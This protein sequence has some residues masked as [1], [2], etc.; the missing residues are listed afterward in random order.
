MEPRIVSPIFELR[1]STRVEMRSRNS[2]NLKFTELQ[3]P[4]SPKT[5]MPKFSILSPNLENL[6]FQIHFWD[7]T[8]KMFCNTLKSLIEEQTRINEQG[9]IFRILHKKLRAG[10]T[11]NLKNLN[12]HAL[13]LG[14][15]EYYICRSE[16]FEL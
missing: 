15:S 3:N 11:E 7:V 12:E 14:T 16:K 2:E 9:G 1:Y 8:S 5:L 13:L 10:W 4:E 6:G